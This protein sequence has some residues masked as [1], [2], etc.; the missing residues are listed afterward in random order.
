V[1]PRRFSAMIAGSVQIRPD[2]AAFRT[3]PAIFD[4]ELA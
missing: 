1:S 3:E 4:G 2:V